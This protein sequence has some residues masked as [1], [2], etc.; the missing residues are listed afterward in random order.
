M[1]KTVDLYKTLDELASIAE[2]TQVGIRLDPGFNTMVLEFLWSDGVSRQFAISAIE[3]E[4]MFDFL[5]HYAERAGNEI[6]L[7]RMREKPDAKVDST[8]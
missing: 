2:A 4:S 6:R 7:Y 3:M 8:P 1:I 5:K